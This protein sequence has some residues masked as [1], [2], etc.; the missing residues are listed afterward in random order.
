LP[1]KVSL[2]SRDQIF[3]L[4]LVGVVFLSFFKEFYPPEVT[5]LA[6]SA[7]LLATEIIEMGDFLTVFSSSAPIAVVT[8]YEKPST[9]R[10]PAAAHPARTVT[11][12]IQFGFSCLQRSLWSRLSF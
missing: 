5:A 12:P 3:V 8:G 6:A 2:M 9:L 7:V 10:T 1:S 11:G 4:A